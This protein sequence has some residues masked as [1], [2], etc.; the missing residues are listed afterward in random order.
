MCIVLIAGFPAASVADMVKVLTPVLITA[1]FNDHVPS[2][3]LL[4]AKEP[5]VVCKFIASLLQLPDICCTNV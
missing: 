1:S 2:E 4:S 5:F 3:Q